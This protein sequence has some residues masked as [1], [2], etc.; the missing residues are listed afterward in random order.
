MAA[1]QTLFVTDL[2]LQNPDSNTGRITIA[3][4]GQPVFDSAL[5][6]FRDLDRHFVSPLRVPAG[7]ALTTTVVC[8]GPPGGQCTAAATFGAFLKAN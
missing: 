4:D 6:F 2:V 3:V 1:G 5:D 8:T 7:S